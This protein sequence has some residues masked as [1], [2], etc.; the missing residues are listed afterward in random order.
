KG[1]A[2]KSNTLAALAINTSIALR[3]SWLTD[4]AI[5]VITDVLPLPD[6]LAI[7][8]GDLLT[9]LSEA[10]LQK[11][12]VAEAEKSAE[13][14]LLILT[15][16][17]DTTELNEKIV[18]A[19]KQK[20][21][22]ERIKGA[23]TQSV[24]SL[25]M[26]LSIY[27]Y[28]NRNAAKIHIELGKSYEA[29]GPADEA[30]RHYQRALSY[31]APVNPADPFSNPAPAQVYAENTI[32]EAL[33]AK[34]PA[35]VKKYRSP[36]DIK[37]LEAA[38]N[39][40]DLAFDTERKLMQYL[41]YD[42][43]KLL[44]LKTSRKRS[45]RAINLCWQLQQLTGNTHWAEK[46]FLFAE[47]SKAFVLLES[48]RRN[49][50]HSPVQ[51]DSLYQRV[52]FLQL[53]LSLVERTIMEKNQSKATA[54]L[55]LL[56]QQK[57]EL[58]GQLLLAQTAFS[59]NNSSYYNALNRQDSFSVP[60]LKEQLL[61][62]R[63]SMLEYFYG[64]SVVYFF[65]FAGDKPPVLLKADEHLSQATDSF[66]RFFTDKNQINNAPEA[67]QA[68]AYALYHALGF[69]AIDLAG[70]RQLIIIP[71]GPLNL[72]PFEALTTWSSALKNPRLFPYLML[73]QQ[74][75]YG[76]SA[77]TLLKQQEHNKIPA[78]SIAAFAPVFASGEKGQSP[79]THTIGE[80]NGIQQQQPKGNYF[81]EKEATLHNFRAISPNAGI[82]HIA[83]HAYA[84]TTGATQPA[85]I[86]YDSTLYL[87]E[88]YGMPVRA[89]LVV[90]SACET[91][92][93]TI[94]KSEGAMSL[95]RG[96]Y[97]AGAKN[98][99]TSLWNVEDKSSAEIFNG[100]YQSLSGSDYQ[101]ALYKAKL[102]Y[103][104]TSSN[105]SPYYWAGFIHIGHERPASGRYP[106]VWML[107]TGIA[108]LLILYIITKR[109]RPTTFN[110]TP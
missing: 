85:I 26:A 73:E 13:G 88:L 44:M 47:K 24:Q 110:S 38:V 89:D 63:T 62:K 91:G 39:C 30:L 84:D 35:L 43:S 77:A 100:F 32:M 15:A 60:L 66:L 16:L 74:L 87:Q 23:Y 40:Y 7:K 83:S 93:G 78:G 4:S 82:I 29:M 105:A 42:E 33:D 18:M 72:V 54:G 11:G 6:I 59:R 79:L 10:Q 3:E 98:I 53:Q 14:A 90:L 49:I 108:S 104:N 57:S 9:T 19:L 109:K 92:I 86:F 28:Q 34:A 36:S 12:L 25:K 17:A 96:F 80:L 37:Y 27:T 107:F 31:V 5:R 56:H 41:S 69:P 64:D 46:A 70:T 21:I 67:Y 95:A 103:L 52:Q 106:F 50:A 20:G 94:N 2:R 61:D 65:S 58:E 51:N 45:S 102:H 68:A 48:I 55:S 1:M 75:T 71:D 8:R 22:L 99:I 101:Q 76:Y 81:R 97:Y